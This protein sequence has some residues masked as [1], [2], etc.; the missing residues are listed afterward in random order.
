ME[1]PLMSFRIDNSEAVAP[2]ATADLSRI[3]SAPPKARWRL[4]FGKLLAGVGTL[5][6]WW[7]IGHV[8]LWAGHVLHIVK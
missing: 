8:A 3:V 2:I 7:C 6:L 4:S 1:S 5:F